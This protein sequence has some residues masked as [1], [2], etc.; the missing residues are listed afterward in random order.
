MCVHYNFVAPHGAKCVLLSQKVLDIDIIVCIHVCMCVSACLCVCVC[1]CFCIC[2]CVCVC[3]LFLCN[4]FRGPFWSGQHLARAPI[5]LSL[6]TL[7]FT[8]ERGSEKKEEVG[9]GGSGNNRLLSPEGLWKKEQG[10]R[11]RRERNIG[12]K[13]CLLCVLAL[14]EG[15]WHVWLAI[16]SVTQAGKHCVAL[17]PG[18][19][20]AKD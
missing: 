18:I 4:T 16:N 11:K 10:V 12:E 8:L 6:L 14:I 20:Q 13:M 17:H 15:L 1:M 5:R 2:V 7:S 19:Q 3:S 9:G